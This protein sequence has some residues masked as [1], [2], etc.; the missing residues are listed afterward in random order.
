MLCSSNTCGISALNGVSHLISPTARG[1]GP[2][3]FLTFWAVSSTK[4]A[5]YATCRTYHERWKRM[6]HFD[7]THTDATDR[8]RQRGARGHPRNE[9]PS[10]TPTNNPPR[11][12]RLPLRHQRAAR[13]PSVLHDWA[14]WRPSSRTSPFSQR[15]W[16]RGPDNQDPRPTCTCQDSP[17]N[18]SCPQPSKLCQAWSSASNKITTLRPGTSCHT[19]VARTHQ[20]G[21]G[22]ALQ[23]KDQ[24]ND[25]TLSRTENQEWANITRDSGQENQGAGQPT[26]QRT[27]Q[28][29]PNGRNRPECLGSG[30]H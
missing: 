26:P 8:N 12:H 10:A 13:S 20:T 2:I 23:A 25:H 24:Q 16:P 29:W 4:R 22:R 9:E 7:Q 28:S 5:H 17:A 15:T 27:R 14:R 1:T 21:T 18:A 6:W 19:D 30:W 3:H 11:R